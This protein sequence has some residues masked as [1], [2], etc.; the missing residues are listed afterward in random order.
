MAAKNQPGQHRQ[1]GLV[2]NVNYLLDKKGT[3]T[4]SSGRCEGSLI[5]T[6]ESLFLSKREEKVNLDFCLGY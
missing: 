4:L 1:L 5:L 6:H 2:L 3:N